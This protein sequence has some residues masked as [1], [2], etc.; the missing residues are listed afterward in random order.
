MNESQAPP[1]QP[2]AIEI[3]SN[4]DLGWVPADAFAA[5]LARRLTPE[6]EDLRELRTRLSRVL[7]VIQDP[8]KATEGQ[9]RG[10]QNYRY[11][12]LSDCLKA[13]RPLL[14]AEGL[15]LVQPMRVD[16]EILTVSTQVCYGLAAETSELSAP[17]PKG[18]QELGSAVTYLRRYTLC[19]L[20]AVQGDEADPDKE[21][22][23]DPAAGTRKEAIKEQAQARAAESKASS[24]TA[25]Q[26]MSNDELRAHSEL[27]QK[28]AKERGLELPARGV[29]TAVFQKKGW[30]MTSRA[31]FQEWRRLLDDTTK[32]PGILTFLRSA[33]PPATQTE[34]P[35]ES[36]PNEVLKAITAFATAQGFDYPNQEP[37]AQEALANLLHNL[38]EK[39]GDMSPT[40]WGA[41]LAK[42][43]DPR[44]TAHWVAVLGPCYPPF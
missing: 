39:Y 37:R 40:K 44:R 21:V 32:E 24:E 16:G 23:A 42:L 36:D 20:L 26:P 41:V 31:H 18:M 6:Q 30:D 35:M 33:F 14:S 10:R 5:D 1:Q 25:P 2:A 8:L 3:R 29:L 27:L 4:R 19:A 28:W 43:L 11:A 38:N 15:A 22:K 34:A 13:V 7:A 9:V 17:A 12:D